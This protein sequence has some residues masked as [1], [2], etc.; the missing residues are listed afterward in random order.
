MVLRRIGVWSAARL[1]GGICA[2]MGLIIGAI[3]ALAALAGGMVGAMEGGDSGF[4]SWVFGAMAGVGAIIVLPL[5]YGVF[6]LIG[7][8]LG[9]VL[10]N[11]FAG[12][13]GGIEVELQ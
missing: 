6:G 8:A 13:F 9:A 1:Y 3:V 11:L 7:G 2:T 12:L 4:G 5:L 10:Y